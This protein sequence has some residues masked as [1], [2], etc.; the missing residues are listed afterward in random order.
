MSH[1]APSRIRVEK[2]AITRVVRTLKGKG[3]LIA[4]EGQEVT[5]EEIIG[6]ATVSAGF[7]MM[8]LSSTLG[9]PPRESEKYLIR[10]MGQRIY[11]G[12]LLAFKKG[13][14]LAGKKVIIS[15][16]DGVLD[17]LDSRTGDL[18]ISFFPKEV[19]LP[20]GVYG[21]V[22]KVDDQ[23][24]QV[25]I[26]TQ[27]S[28]VHGVFGSGRLRDG[29]LH[30]VG[31][32][33]DLISKDAIGDQY[34]EQILVA[35]SLLFKDVLSASISTGVKGIIVGGISAGDYKGIS[36][37]RLLFSKK[38]EIDIGISIIICEGFGSIPIGDDIFQLLSANEGKFV[39]IEG[40]KALINLPSFSSSSLMKVRNTRLPDLPN[41][42][43]SGDDIQEALELKIGS[44]V[45]IV[46][47]SYLGEQGKIL[48]IDDSPTVLTSKVQTYLVTVETARRKIQVPVANVEVIL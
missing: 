33:E 9:V 12:E 15:P 36:G 18:K 25:V 23:R 48:A 43:D 6:S 17:Y 13:W 28:R 45:R 30:I 47:N 22:E 2:D 46:G 35:G 1:F 34:S 24:G 38:T 40:N 39:F 14:M 41:G 10:K 32:K 26:R 29:T 37:G 42:L 5:P 44:R 16:T 19:K 27:V 3:R 8:N 20:A 31:K 21:I 11:K 7:R 4:K